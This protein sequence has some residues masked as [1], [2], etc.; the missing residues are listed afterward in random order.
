MARQTNGR[1]RTLIGLMIAV[2]VPLALVAAGRPARAAVL[3]AKDEAL[4]LAFP[5]AERVEERTFIL[6]DAQTEDVERRAR[7]K[8]ETQIWTI[9]V[10]WKGSEV[11]GYAIIDTHNVRTLPETFMAVIERNGS[12]RRVDVLAFHEP[13]E[14]M[15][16]ERWVGQ[17]TGR[18]LDDDLKLGAGIQG[19][20]GATLSA[21]A[22]TAGARRALALVAVL[23]QPAAGEGK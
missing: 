3:L 10:G 6:T 14:Y 19:I 18:K 20:T 21:Q 7:A 15:P 13:P 2:G 1:T 17:F 11:Q 12:L 16:T 4:A 5:D 23:I 9:Y 22:M 8:L